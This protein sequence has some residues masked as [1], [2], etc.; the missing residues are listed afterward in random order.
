VKQL[1]FCIVVALST[2]SFAGKTVTMFQPTVQELT[3][4][5]LNDAGANREKVAFRQNGTIACAMN[6]QP[7][8]KVYEPWFEGSIDEFGKLHFDF[9]K[10]E[11]GASNDV[12]VCTRSVLVNNLIKLEPGRYRLATKVT[13][14]KIKY[15]IR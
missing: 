10:Y 12:V 14:K 3:A 15:E 11:G 2:A 4:T 9:E 8:T 6:P 1:L 7:G 5:P 13:F